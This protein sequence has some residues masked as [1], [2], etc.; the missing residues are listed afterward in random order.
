MPY[1]WINEPPVVEITDKNDFAALCDRFVKEIKREIQELSQP[2]DR[3]SSTERL[4]GQLLVTARVA[5]DARSEGPNSKARCFAY[6][7]PGKMLGLMRVAIRKGLNEV[8]VYDLAIRPGLEIER[9]VLIEHAVNLSEEAGLKGRIFHRS[10]LSAQNHM[11]PGGFI[12]PN[13]G[14]DWVKVDHKWRLKRYL[15]WHQL[16]VGRETFGSIHPQPRWFLS[17]LHGRQP[18]S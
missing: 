11:W 13:E 3:N 10:S 14:D 9:R 5:G 15:P 7:H 1:T 17:V 12:D 8:E 2:S 4:A 18:K 6:M 16:T